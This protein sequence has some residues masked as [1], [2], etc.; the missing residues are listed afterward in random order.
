MTMN[1]RNFN[2]TAVGAALLP[3]L[4]SKTVAQPPVN[5]APFRFSVM[6]WTLNKYGPA[7]KTMEMVA[8]A[9]YT[10]I[11]LVGEWHK[12][13]DTDAA[14][15]LGRTKSLGLTIDSMAGVRGFADPTDMDAIAADVKTA[16]AMAQ[17][18]DCKQ[19]IM[20]S[21]KRMDLPNQHAGAIENL[22]RLNDL[23][24]KADMQIVIE[25]IDVL[26]NPPIYLTSVAEGFEMVR[27]VNSPHIRVL[28]DLYHEQ[29]Q[30]GNLIEKLE[31]NIDSIALFHVADVPG[32][33]E[34][35]TGEIRYDAI[36]RKMAELKYTGY[37]AMEFYPTGEPVASLRIAR[38]Q[39][40]RAATQA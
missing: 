19:I 26:E 32:R 13:T 21:G 12:W 25:P 34:P 30:A 36:Y 23:V 14:R 6:L 20:T 8:Q 7:E 2:R 33:H 16:I 18:I 35:G 39:A 11:E 37:V 1:R 22:K 27:A 24:A 17:K 9:G 40:I 29:R 28:Y 10:G 15:F 5:A 31:K 3:W 38:E 4:A